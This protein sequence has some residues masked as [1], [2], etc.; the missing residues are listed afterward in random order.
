LGLITV[1]SS[2]ADFSKFVIDD[3]A[4]QAKLFKLA[5]IQPQ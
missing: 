3:M 4:F 5:N 2:P 1:G